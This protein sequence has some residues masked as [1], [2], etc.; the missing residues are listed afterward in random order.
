MEYRSGKIANSS[1]TSFI[2]TNFTNKNLTLLDF[3]KE[4]LFL[5]NNYNKIYRRYCNKVTEK[6]FLDSAKARCQD[7]SKV[8]RNDDDIY[9]Q[10]KPILQPGE[11]LMTF[12]DEDGDILGQVFDYML[13]D[14]GSTKRFTWRFYEFNR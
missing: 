8:Y 10:C 11:N 1:S 13:R 9:Y 3:A 7:D 14:G 12:G 6:Q 2:V 4:V 5:V